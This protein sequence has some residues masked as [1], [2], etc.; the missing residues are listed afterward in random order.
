MRLAIFAPTPRSYQLACSVM[1]GLNPDELWTRVT[2]DYPLPQV[3]IMSEPLAQTVANRWHEVDCCLFILTVGAVV[4]LISPLLSSK[5]TDPGVVAVDEQGHFVV[6]LSGGHKGG[7]DALAR[8]AAALLNVT[9]V[10]TSAATGRQ[11]PALDCLGAPYGWRAGP[12][13][14]VELTTAMLQNQLIAV[15]QTTGSQLWRNLLPHEH[16]FQ[17]NPDGS[18]VAQLWISDQYPP[19]DLIPRGCWYPRTLWVGVGCE[20][21][22]AAAVVEHGIRQ[23]LSEQNLAVEAIAGLA[24]I[25][26]KKDEA[27]LLELSHHFD[28]PIRLF[29]NAVLA[30]QSVPNPSKTVD[31]CVG[32]PSVAEAA[33]LEAAQVST[34]LIPKHVFKTEREGSCTIAIAQTEQA[35]TP[36]SGHL[37]L[38]GT[39]P[40]D[41]T[42]LTAAARSAIGQAHVVIGYQLYLNLLRPICHPDQII[43]ATPITYEIQRAERAIELAQQGLKV[44]VVSSGDSGIYGMA[45]LV[46]AALHQ[47]GWDGQ[48]PT[49]EVYPGITA[50]Q[51][52]AARVGAP[53]MH[54]FCAISLSDLMTPWP[55]IERRIEAAASADFVI[56]LYNPRSQKR[57]QGIQIAL[58][59]LLKFRDPCTP[60]VLARSVYRPDETILRT[61]LGSINVEQIDMLTLVLIGNQ[62]TFQ[63]HQWLITP[64]GY[65]LE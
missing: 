60:V 48:D 4:R 14:W 26:L 15:H 55:V 44:A 38:I 33:A 40:G 30:R 8:R 21:G 37:W 28:W 13:Q 65:Q 19:H 10:I 42:Q 31:Q 62:T 6:S 7:A 16:P 56:A 3:R 43:E 53:L 34:L 1:L 32:T 36:H 52:A 46:L 57:T 9:P 39:G 35:Y 5:H 29:P 27:G 12:S 51:A 61:T 64:R 24:S 41:L 11:F 58:E 50:L 18:E 45:G 59:I 22:T 23:T 47:A 49:V 54:D 20:R 63:H 25:D 2:P 17:F